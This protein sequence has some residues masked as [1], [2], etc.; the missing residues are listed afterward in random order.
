MYAIQETKPVLT[1][2]FLLCV[3][4]KRTGKKW[5]KNKTNQRKLKIKVVLLTSF[6]EA[7]FTR[8]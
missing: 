2:E 3:W 6:V 7:V 4:K 1:L 5:K 8:A